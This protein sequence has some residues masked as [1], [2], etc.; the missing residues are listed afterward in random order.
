[1]RSAKPGRRRGHPSGQ[2]FPT[3]TPAPSLANRAAPFVQLDW[4]PGRLSFILMYLQDSETLASALFLKCNLPSLL[5]VI[6]NDIGRTEVF[7][8]K[9]FIYPI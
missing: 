1:M 9:P 3:R 5:R 6:E 7:G 8:I 4:I 2:E